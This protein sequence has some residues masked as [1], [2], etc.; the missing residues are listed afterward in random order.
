MYE[1]ALE[2]QGG[3]TFTFVTEGI[4]PA[5]DMDLKLEP[6]RVIDSPQVTHIRY[7]VVR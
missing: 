5:L 6:D 7:R 4:E 1:L 2:K 3:T